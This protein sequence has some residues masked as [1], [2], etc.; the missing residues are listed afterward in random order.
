MSACEMKCRQKLTN[1]RRTNRDAVDETVNWLMN[2]HK[3][4]QTKQGVRDSDKHSVCNEETTFVRVSSAKLD[5]N[6]TGNE[7]AVHSLCHI[8]FSD[9][10][11]TTFWIKYRISIYILCSIRHLSTGPFGCKLYSG[12]K[13][14]TASAGTD[15]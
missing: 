10:T 9:T 4:R 12:S 11:S 2:N 6:S 8:T 5:H 3:S 7:S 13:Q 14:Y 1:Q 15:C